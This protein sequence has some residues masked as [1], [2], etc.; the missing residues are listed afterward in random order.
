MSG[1]TYDGT[2][3]PLAE[4]VNENTFAIEPCTMHRERDHGHCVHC[5]VPVWADEERWS[6]H[7]CPPGFLTAPEP[8]RNHP[9][10]PAPP[11]VSTESRERL[12]V[13][14]SNE[15]GEVVVLECVDDSED[16][17][18]RMAVWSQQRF[19]KP[20]HHHVHLATE[21]IVTTYTRH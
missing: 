2:E 9:E 21:T 20:Y 18:Q 13:R 15:R 1:R 10:V 16:P 5:G 17:E 7:T 3:V 4:L 19:S 12:V 14:G 8:T 11:A 6:D